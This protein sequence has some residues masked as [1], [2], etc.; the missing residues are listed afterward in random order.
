MKNPGTDDLRLRSLQPLLQLDPIGWVHKS[1]R[2]LWAIEFTTF[3]V[4]FLHVGVKD[5]LKRWILIATACRILMASLYSD[6]TTPAVY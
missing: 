6:G 4:L 5:T 1:V 3:N 2:N